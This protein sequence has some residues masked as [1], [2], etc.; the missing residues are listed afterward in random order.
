MIGL[1]ILAAGASTRLGTPKQL[2]PYEGKSLLRH[3]AETALASSCRPLVVV[4][5]SNPAPLRLELE[6]LPVHCVENPDWE[7]GM[8]S[9]IRAGMKALLAASG[10]EREAALFML[11]DQPH[12]SAA[13]IDALIAAYRQTVSPLVAS[14]YGG[15]LGV[16]ALFDRSLFSELSLLN[17]AE[18]AKQILQRHRAQ[19]IGIPFPKGTVDI[20]TPED[21]LRLKKT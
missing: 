12:V 21:Y 19:A 1:I 14:E 10:P 5:G 9:S 3:A 16:P 11:C 2:L 13:L 8:G 7:Q 6:G 18:G 17:G 4:L 15:T 20:D